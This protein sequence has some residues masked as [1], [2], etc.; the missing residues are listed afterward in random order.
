MK[1]FSNSVVMLGFF[2]SACIGTMDALVQVRGN[3]GSAGASGERCEVF[4]QPTSR[5]SAN[6]G[7]GREV[8]GEFVLQFIV[9]P[10][11]KTYRATVKCGERVRLEKEI[12]YR[13]FGSEPYDLGSI[14][15]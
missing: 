6:L 3:T 10:W 8:R 13:A 4:L 12:E 11:E 7:Y 9:H 1:L 15:P 2:A 5:D 14:A